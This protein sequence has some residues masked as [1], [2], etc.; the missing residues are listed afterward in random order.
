MLVH[1][2]GYLWQNFIKEV[3]EGEEHR[4]NNVKFQQDKMEGR[5]QKLKESLA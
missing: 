2:I 3:Q 1:W 4:K 5:A